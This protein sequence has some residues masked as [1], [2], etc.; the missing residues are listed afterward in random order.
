MFLGYHLQQIKEGKK[1]GNWQQACLKLNRNAEPT[2]RERKKYF[3]RMYVDLIK[4]K[5]FMSYALDENEKNS[6]KRGSE[7]MDT[8]TTNTCC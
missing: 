6:G 7:I 2:T 5:I 1:V 3:K 8:H 4:L